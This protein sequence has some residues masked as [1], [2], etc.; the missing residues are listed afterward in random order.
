[1][2]GLDSVKH[3]RRHSRAVYSC[4]IC[5]GQS[6]VMAGQ[7]VYHVRGRSIVVIDAF[8]L[9]HYSQS[10]CCRFARRSNVKHY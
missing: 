7:C 5:N 8:N 10:R 6:G 9:R 1:M 3:G 4:Y 2:G